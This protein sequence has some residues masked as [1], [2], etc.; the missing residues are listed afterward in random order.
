MNDGEDRQANAG[1]DGVGER[2]HD[3]FDGAG[4]HQQAFEES[5]VDDPKDRAEAEVNAKAEPPGGHVGWKFRHRPQ[6]QFEMNREAQPPSKCHHHAHH[7]RAEYAERGCALDLHCTPSLKPRPNWAFLW[8]NATPVPEPRPFR[9]GML[10]ASSSNSTAR[11][12]P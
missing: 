5:A 8:K 2:D 10:R 4:A 11:P 1:D 12:T 9:S 7:D 3:P 6:H